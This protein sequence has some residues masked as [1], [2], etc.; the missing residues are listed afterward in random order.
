MSIKFTIIVPSYNAEGYIE[1][2]VRSALE[3]D[4][5][6]CEVIVIDNDHT[7]PN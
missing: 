7:V 5:D 4:Y 3:Q 2:C 6:N 1:K